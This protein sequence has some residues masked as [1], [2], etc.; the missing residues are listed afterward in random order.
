MVSVRSRPPGP[1]A[2]PGVFIVLSFIAMFVDIEDHLTFSKSLVPEIAGKFVRK[3]GEFW[4]IEGW[5]N[6]SASLLVF[7]FL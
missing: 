7:V 2:V 5:L 1:P 3:E 4:I 6:N